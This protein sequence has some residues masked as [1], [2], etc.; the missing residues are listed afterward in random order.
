MEKVR[1]WCG[2]PSD[3]GRLKI[4]SDHVGS[5][6]IKTR[7]LTLKSYFDVIIK[8]LNEIYNATSM[9]YYLQYEKKWL[10]GLCVC[11]PR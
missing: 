7:N 11:H 3:R 4:R 1:P 6:L 5:Q 2:Q 9:S 10:S 8:T